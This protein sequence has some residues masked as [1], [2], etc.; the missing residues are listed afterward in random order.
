MVCSL[1]GEI[2]HARYKRTF[3]IF[4]LKNSPKVL[5]VLIYDMEMPSTNCTTCDCPIPHDPSKPGRKVCQ[6]CKIKQAQI[7][8]SSSYENYLRNLYSQSKSNAR[9]GKRA[10]DYK[11]ELVPEDLVDLWKKQK[12]RC[13]ISGV[14]LTHHKDGSGAKDYN[15]SIDRISGQKGYTVANTQLVCYRINIMKHTLSEDMFYW[16]VKTINDSSCD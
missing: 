4:F 16:W 7:R 15:A 5:A 10:S 8:I 11:W 13:A 12:G 2:V 14:F 9:P 3:Y 1:G 6:S